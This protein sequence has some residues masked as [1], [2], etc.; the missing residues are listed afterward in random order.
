MQ[1][2]RTANVQEFVRHIWGVELRWSQRLAALPV[3][4]REEMPAGPLDALFDLHRRAV[5]I[6]RGLLAAP[7]KAGT[8]P[9]RLTSARFR[10]RHGAS[11]GAK[12]G[13]TCCSTASAIGRN[14][15][16]WCARPGS[17]RTSAA[18]CCSALRC[19]RQRRC[20]HFS[21]LLEAGAAKHRPALRGLEGNRG[22]RAAL[23]ARGAG[24]RPNP[25]PPRAR[26]A[27][28]CLQCLGSFLN[29]LSW[30]KTC[31]PAVKTNSAPQSLHSKTR[32]VNSMT[33]F[34]R[35][36]TKHRNRP[37]LRRSV[38]VA[39]PCLRS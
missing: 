11:P 27:L 18:T 19:A 37:W 33:G 7:A 28:H 23:R 14:W 39:V 32:S 21:H 26:F 29:C 5:E 8:S 17:P 31:S 20:L 38:P 15:L 1:Y 16:L 4:A 13:D 2:W 36:G 35:T 22:L 9:L 12:S 3:L 24:F 25:L 34:P 30:K 10:R 6:F